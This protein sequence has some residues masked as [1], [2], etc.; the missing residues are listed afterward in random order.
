MASGK[1]P[2]TSSAWTFSA[3]RTTPA[4]GD[5]VFAELNDVRGLDAR[6]DALTADL[7]RRVRHEPLDETSARHLAERMAI[8]LQA[9][10]LLR[11]APASIADAF[12]ATRVAGGG[13]I[14]FGTLPAGTDMTSIIERAWPVR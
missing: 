7:D 8:A 14:A 9:A 4:A 2:A 13:G 3:L 5:A 11:H 12:C 1:A 10:E 6:L